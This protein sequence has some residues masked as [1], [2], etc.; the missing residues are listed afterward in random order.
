MALTTALLKPSLWLR[1][2]DN[3][4]ITWKHGDRE[5]QGFL[6]H[7]NGRVGH[8]VYRW[9]LVPEKGRFPPSLYIKHQAKANNNH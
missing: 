8:W 2:V 4:F 1:Y 7:L 3:G 9:F 6:G 5:L